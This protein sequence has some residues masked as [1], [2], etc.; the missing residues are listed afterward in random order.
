MNVIIYISAGALRTRGINPWILNCKL[1][2]E[3]HAE[4][5]FNFIP[6]HLGVL[7]WINWEVN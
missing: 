3:G 5:I 6:G 4:F 2:R 1:A 7:V